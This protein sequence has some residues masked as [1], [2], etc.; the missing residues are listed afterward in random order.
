[1]TSRLSLLI[2]LPF[3]FAAAVLAQTEPKPIAVHEHEVDGVDVALMDV[4]RTSTDTVTVI[5][6]SSLAVSKVHNGTAF[7][8][9]QNG[10]YSITV[11]NA[12]SGP[13]TSTVTVE[14][15]LVSGLTFVS[16]GGTGWSCG[17]VGADVTCNSTAAIGANSDSGA[18]TL[19]VGVTTPLTSI[20]NSANLS[21]GGGAITTSQ[22]T[23][24]VTV[25]QPAAVSNVTSTTPNGTY[26]TGA[27]IVITVAFTNPVT[28][29]GSPLLALN[30]GGTA[31]YSSGSGTST[32]TFSYTVAAGQNTADLD[33]TSTSALSLNGGTIQDPNNN[34]AS[35]TLPAPGAARSLGFNKNIVINTHP[36]HPPD[37]SHAAAS[38]ASI[39]F[40][41]RDLTPVSIVGVTD[42]DR[43]HVTIRI[44]RIRQD[45]PTGSS[46]D[47]RNRGFDEDRCPDGAGIGSA[48]ARVR[49]ERLASG[50]GRVYT[51]YFTALDGHGGETPGTV[52]VSVPR[53]IFLHRT[54][55]DG[56]PLFDSTVCGH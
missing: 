22:S 37:V 49:A 35:L 21:G 32:L 33:Y 31:V 5:Q 56:G 40:L 25:L 55:V 8:K 9:G 4:R 14:D 3:A 53:D 29:T 47:D 51:I 27:L 38:P 43:D 28:V 42:P 17:H 12:G 44:D 10:S 23:D 36:N 54:A 24:T 15:L 13:T 41:D 50:N 30:S 7:T 19:T 39:W 26:G 1:M 11:H 20:Q 48:I 6:P 34:S 46:D 18:I 45:E 16:A 52:K 2:A